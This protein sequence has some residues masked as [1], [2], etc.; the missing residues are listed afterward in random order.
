MLYAIGDV[1]GRLDLA[2]KLYNNILDDIKTIKDP[3]G[4][5]IIWLGDYCDRGPSSKKVLD[6]IMNLKDSE[7]IKHIFLEG[8]HEDFLINVVKNPTANHVYHIWMRNGG[9]ETLKSF[10]ID[11]QY[12]ISKL[13][14]LKPYAQW[15]SKLPFYYEKYD[16]L[17]CHS[18][19]IRID[20]PLEFQRQ[21]LIWGRPTSDMYTGY[22][23]WIIHGHTP[24]SNET[25]YVDFCRVCIDT[26]AWRNGNK[27]KLAFAV[28]L[29]H[30]K[31]YKEDIKFI[32]AC[33]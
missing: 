12:F 5:E 22:D 3:L 28:K 9:L 13:D 4:A 31:C 1:H 14:I 25:P 10:G 30:G 32:Q 33:L 27:S 19:F 21:N 18:G 23:K 6:F 7:N 8:N 20:E 17:F 11:N 15:L 29:P 2:T 24:T 26:G 16:Y